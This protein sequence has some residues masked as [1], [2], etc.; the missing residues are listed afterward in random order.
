MFRLLTRCADIDCFES[1]LN[2]LVDMEMDY[3]YRFRGIMNIDMKDLEEIVRMGENR[4]ILPK[5]P[6]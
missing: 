4:D 3:T 1:L 5:R 2:H 6:A